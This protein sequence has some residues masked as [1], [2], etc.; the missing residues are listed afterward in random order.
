MHAPLAPSS[1]HIW[2]AEGGCPGSVRMQ[3]LYPD[4]EDSP[5][6]REGTAAHW[7]ATETLQG[8]DV[9]VGAIAPNGVPITAEMVDCAQGFLLDVRDTMR[10]HPNG[11]LSVETRVHMPIIHAEN[12]GTPDADLVDWSAKFIAVWDYKFGHRFVD[13]AGNLQMV[14]YA[15]GVLQRL[16]VPSHDWPNWRISL[17]IVQPRNYH[18]VGPVREWQTDGRKLLDEYVPQLFEAAQKATSPDAP[19]RTN[20]HCRDCSARH[21]CP[22]LQSA[23]AL[24]MDIAGQVSPVELPPHALGLELRQLDDAMTR[25]K[26]RQT[27]L[28]EMALGMIRG[29]KLVPFYSAEHT[30]GREKWTVPAA[31]I[32]AL[33]EVMGA[34]AI[35]KE[36]EPVTPNQARD[37][38]RKAGI[39]GSV[40]DAYAIRPRGALRLARVDDHA[41]KLAFD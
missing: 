25:L 20:D 30:T 19:L 8:R 41:A 36:P 18:A 28:E 24:A 38:F 15:V 1:A 26:A 22:A 32:F 4:A 34:P 33:A 5:E 40:I 13:A 23:A 29:G 12:W 35:A 16:G 9:G 10:A 37:I 39:D 14:D 7:Y 6:A 2:G 3:Q 21:A 17:N 11:T 31:E 27:G